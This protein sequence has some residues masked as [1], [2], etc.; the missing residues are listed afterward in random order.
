MEKAKREKRITDDEVKTEAE[1]IASSIRSIINPLVVRRSRIDLME[2]PA[3]EEDLKLQ[4]IKPVIPDDPKELNYE[5][6]ENS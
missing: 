4:G 5:L 6:S 1:R 2:I 3:Y